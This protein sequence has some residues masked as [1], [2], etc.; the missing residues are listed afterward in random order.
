MENNDIDNFY[1]KIKFGFICIKTL[2]GV[3]SLI[4][5]I[6]Y[7]HVINNNIFALFISIFIFDVINIFGLILW[8]LNINMNNKNLIKWGGTIFILLYNISLVTW[9][10]IIFICYYD[11]LDVFSYRYLIW[12]FLIW[13]MILLLACVFMTCKGIGFILIKLHKYAGEKQFK[14][15]THCIFCDNNLINNH[16]IIKKL[17]SQH[18][19]CS[20]CIGDYKDNTTIILLNCGHHF[21]KECCK[22]WIIVKKTCPSCLKTITFS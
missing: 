1:K 16:V 6:Y 17:D 2:I 21:D 8:F 12:R 3:I 19:V 10:L 22:E 15:L 20:I 14:K 18:N 11:Q 9:I 13:L 7:A 4:T 5:C